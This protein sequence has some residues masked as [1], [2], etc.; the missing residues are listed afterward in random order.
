MS[1][2]LFIF[3]PIFIKSNQFTH[4]CNSNNIDFD[5]FQ[6]QPIDYIVSCSQN[7]IQYLNIDKYNH[8][9]S[10]SIYQ[11]S[12]VSLLCSP[13]CIDIDLFIFDQPELILT[14]NCIFRNIT[15]YNSPTFNIIKNANIFAKNI[16]IYNNSY[17][18]PF[19]S[20]N[21][22]YTHY[23]TEPF[24][25]SNENPS[26]LKIIKRYEYI[27]YTQLE[28]NMSN[29]MTIDCFNDYKITL[30]YSMIGYYNFIYTKSQNSSYFRG[31]RYVKF[32]NS[33]IKGNIRSY[34][35]SYII[36]YLTLRDNVN[37]ILTNFTNLNEVDSIIELFNSFYVAQFYLYYPSKRNCIWDDEDQYVSD[38][39]DNLEMSTKWRKMCYGNKAFLFKQNEPN[40]QIIIISKTSTIVIIITVIIVILLIS[41]LS[42]ILTF[43]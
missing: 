38:D 14:N 35:S 40:G 5:I 29:N 31:F 26:H 34:I 3:S 16:I 41:I 13:L 32:I 24:N 19:K 21:A 33:G 12:V 22:I 1:L 37:I 23:S 20:E 25:L 39:F 42:S 10:I 15:I 17:Q 43:S 36:P 8:L 9:N 30:D 11:D 6:N 7:K 18:L 27:C 4:D 2:V 28:F